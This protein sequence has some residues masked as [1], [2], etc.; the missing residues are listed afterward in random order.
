MTTFLP[1]NQIKNYDQISLGLHINIILR[2][3]KKRTATK[4][5]TAVSY[6]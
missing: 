2:L 3:K 6:L 4:L 5:K 1:T